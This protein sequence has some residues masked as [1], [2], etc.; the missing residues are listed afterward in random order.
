M[1]SIFLQVRATSHWLSLSRDQ[2]STI[3]QTHVL[4][5]F[6]SDSTLRMRYYDAE[7]FHARV[8]D[9]M[10]IET[11]DLKAYYFFIEKL[12]DSPIFTENYFELVD[13]IPAIE[14]G[15]QEYEATQ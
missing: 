8:S 7:A 13:I 12:R 10:L 15:F 2:R 1:F 14:N 11:E 5:H 3:F 4:R 9:L 6:Q